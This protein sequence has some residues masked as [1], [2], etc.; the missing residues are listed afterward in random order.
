M[1]TTPAGDDVTE[2]QQPDRRQQYVIQI[3]RNPVG[4]AGE[5]DDRIDNRGSERQSQTVA[6]SPAKRSNYDREEKEVIKNKKFG[7]FLIIQ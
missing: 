1:I 6:E 7:S 3:D 2:N 5:T 4:T